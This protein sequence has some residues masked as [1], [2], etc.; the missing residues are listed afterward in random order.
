MPQPPPSNQPCPTWCTG[1]ERF[2]VRLGKMSGHGTMIWR[3]GT[4]CLEAE[5]VLL[6]SP[7]VPLLGCK[8]K[9]RLRC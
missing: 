8:T 1:T 6:H 9:Q 4:S 5:G 3:N 7:S 2:G